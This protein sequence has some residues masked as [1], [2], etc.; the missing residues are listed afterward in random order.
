MSMAPHFGRIGLAALALLMVAILG[1]CLH[2]D[3]LSQGGTYSYSTN[4]NAHTTYY[5]DDPHTL[6]LGQ[7]STGDLSDG[8]RLN[9]ASHTSPAA[10][11]NVGWTSVTSV[12]I[13]YSLDDLCTVNNVNIS[14]DLL[15]AFNNGGPNDAVISFSPTGTEPGDFGLPVSTGTLAAT[16]NGHH[17]YDIAVP[18]TNARYVKIAFDGGATGEL[19]KYFLD[20]IT[21]EGS[22]IPHSI[23]NPIS[24]DYSA[25]PNAH[26]SYYRDDLKLGGSTTGDLADGIPVTVGA[27]ANPAGDPSVGWLPTTPTDITFDLGG[28]TNLQ[29]IKIGHAGI[30]S[31]AKWAPDDVQVQFSTDGVDFATISAINSSDFALFTGSGGWERDT[32]M[33]PTAVQATHVRLRFDGGGTE[34]TGNFNGYMLDEVTFEGTSALTETLDVVAYSYSIDPDAHGS[35]YVDDQK[36]AGSLTG[37]LTDGAHVSG[38]GYALGDG[39]VGWGA[40]TSTDIVFEL[41]NKSRVDGLLIGHAGLPGAAKWAPDDVEV[42]FSLDGENF[43]ASID[44]SAFAMFETSTAGWQ[45]DDLFIGVPSGEVANFVMLRFDGGGTQNTGNFNGWMLDEVTLYGVGVSVPEP[46]SFVM[47]LIGLIG[48]AS[49]GLRNRKRGC[50]A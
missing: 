49:I 45:R 9:G 19:D 32:L 4:P 44:A 13:M 37:D 43:F 20:E 18:D 42:L 25:N 28:L 1:Q 38:G 39:S 8:A 7:F 11:T 41:G 27:G 30:P 24:Y 22:V 29:A 33:L 17:D 5:L 15:I 14:T 31:S 26:S 35:F 16:V 48:M 50:S 12:D 34:N 46:S 47:A 23:I 3:V 2:A 40:A 6:T 36:K 10:N 21:I